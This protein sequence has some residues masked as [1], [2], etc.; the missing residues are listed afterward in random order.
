MKARGKRNGTVLTANLEKIDRTMRTVTYIPVICAALLLIASEVSLMVYD[1]LGREVA[2]LVNSY[3]EPVYHHVRWNG[4]NSQGRELP[5]GIYIARLV[6]P[7]H[8]ESIK[9]VLMK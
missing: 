8:T 7:E 4:R 2:R 3:I 1:L 5:T 6:T 9:M